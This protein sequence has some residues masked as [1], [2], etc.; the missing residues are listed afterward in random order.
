MIPEF[1]STNFIVHFGERERD[2]NLNLFILNLFSFVKGIIYFKINFI[3][4]IYFNLLF[5]IANLFVLKY[6]HK[7]S[8]NLN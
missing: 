2:K 6:N 7:S 1:R 5:I 4:L 3:L 8:Q